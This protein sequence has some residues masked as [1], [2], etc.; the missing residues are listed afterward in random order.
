MASYYD[1]VTGNLNTGDVAMASDIHQIQRN[2]KD[3]LKNLNADLSDNEAYVL[4]VENEYKNS[5]ILTPAPKNNGEYIDSYNMFDGGDTLDFN[6][7]DIRQ[8]ILKTKTS[9][10]SILTR[11]KNTSNRDI[12]V[13]FEIQDEDEKTIRSNT[14]TLPA[15]QD[16]I[17][18]EVVFDLDFF[19]T[20]PNLDYEELV[21]SE[22]YIPLP[23][24]EDDYTVDADSDNSEDSEESEVPE[25]STAGVSTLYFVIKRT[26]LN[27]TDLSTS[28]DT[29]LDKPNFEAGDLGVYY[30][31]G[32][33]FP[34]EQIFCETRGENSQYVKQTGNIW[35]KDIYAKEPTYLCTGG[36]AIIGGEKVLCQD[37]HISVE[38]GG[39]EA[40]VL[41][42]IYL[43]TDGHLHFA[44]TK[45]SYTTNID[46]FESNPSDVLPTFFLPVALILTY[47][48]AV[49]GTGKE[50][51]IIQHE[52]GQLPASHHERLRKLEKRI[53]WTDDI[54]LP[55]R[56]KYVLSGEDL[57]D[58]NGESLADLPFTTFNEKNK[59]DE[60]QK[61]KDV[62]TISNKNIITTTDEE[63]NSIVQLTDSVIDKITITLKE[64]LK[65]DDG[66]DIKLKETDVLNA[67]AFSEI[68]NM[69]HDSKKG[70]LM[71]KK[72]EAK[73]DKD[74]KNKKTTT[75]TKK[76]SSKA[77]KIIKKF[78]S[79][80]K[81][82]QSDKETLFKE[83]DIDT[84][85]SSTKKTIKISATNINSSNL[86]KLIDSKNLS[87]LLK[88]LGVESETTKKT[89]TK[90]IT[91]TYNPWAD[92]S[93]TSEEKIK[94]K[95]YKINER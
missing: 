77:E 61:K 40:N 70:T 69:V 92:D 18:Y 79:T 63:G 48:N 71:L 94:K 50:P 1:D 4:G 46:E 89:V 3:A 9:L 30:Q 83:F 33:A 26:N 45:T 31:E 67:S 27:E 14:V 49:Y 19:S 58:E 23:V 24:D 11:L 59:D 52:Y 73:E 72:E 35:Y 17:L 34:E 37:T 86:D 76:L 29:E 75:K 74:S 88:E 84:N 28:G 7:M 32:S 68:S 41:T 55:G 42:Q 85:K 16:N 21:K 13:T 87:K 81:I 91:G 25:F 20:P 8:P 62:E 5:F 90:S 36:K 2:I 51:L 10:Y 53:N 95:K 56:I 22:K 39:T 64:K 93:L 80:K 65:D 66:D 78:V 38:G 60:E 54:A 12:P 47:S 15:N 44:H 82:S 57:I 43:G 6:Y